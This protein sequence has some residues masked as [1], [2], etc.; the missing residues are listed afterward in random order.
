M[1]KISVIVPVYK[2]EPYIARCIESVL[3]Q[4]FTDW[5]LILV[6]DGS[7]DK[8]GEICDAYR[9]KDRR[10]TVIHTE[11]HGAC[12]ARALGVQTSSGEYIAFVDSDDYLPGDALSLLLGKAV[13]DN[14]DITVGCAAL[15]RDRTQKE[16]Y[17]QSGLWEKTDYIKKMLLHKISCG[18]V[19]KLFRRQVL[20]ENAFKLPRNVTNNEDLYMNIVAALNSSRIG[21]Y[22]D[23][24]VYLYNPDNMNSVCRTMKVYEEVFFSLC[25]AIWKQLSDHGLENE[26]RNEYLAFVFSGI[27]RFIFEEN[28]RIRN[29]E[30][31]S[32]LLTLSEGYHGGLKSTCVKFVCQH[33]EF[34]YVYYILANLAR[35]I[36]NIWRKLF[37]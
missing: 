22:D 5:E 25:N 30:F 18:P 27:G 26:C 2:A 11:N 35:K 7:P 15:Y 24:V 21:F 34:V 9:E 3:S 36:R 31:M 13:K 28:K 8:A 17:L 33:E 10:I 14:L 6:D 4:D 20:D 12:A 16:H 1:P 37:I 19:T 29:K 23:I 32:N